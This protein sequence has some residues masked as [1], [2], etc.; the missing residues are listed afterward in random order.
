MI[1]VSTK[2]S[3]WEIEKQLTSSSMFMK[4]FINMYEEG[5]GMYDNHSFF[6]GLR[7]RSIL[8]IGLP[9]KLPLD[10]RREIRPQVLSI[11]KFNGDGLGE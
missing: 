4:E 5:A 8:Y 7:F 10:E 6:I 3:F 2:T 11:L 9:L 1:Y